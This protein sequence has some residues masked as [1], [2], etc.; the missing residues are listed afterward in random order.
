MR[1]LG[2]DS[3]ETRFVVSDSS[4]SSDD[5][6]QQ[7]VAQV[8]Q[9]QQQPIPTAPETI[10]IGPEPGIEETTLC[11]YE[12][13]QEAESCCADRLER[14]AVAAAIAYGEL[15][16]VTSGALL[17]IYPESLSGAT[18]VRWLGGSLIFLSCIC[19]LLILGWFRYKL[20]RGGSWRGG[21][22]CL[23]ARSYSAAQ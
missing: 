22:L 16:V 9:Q 21:C 13:W 8:T 20:W 1:N 17:V 14:A 7:E 6:E 23:R 10:S 12:A 5:E 3:Q 18:S 2:P 11:C 15:A 4:S 19:F